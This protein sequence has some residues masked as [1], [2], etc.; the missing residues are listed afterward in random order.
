MSDN[1]TPTPST[2]VDARPALHGESGAGAGRHGNASRRIADGLRAAILSGELPPGTRIRQEEVAANYG[3][4]RIPVRGALNILQSDGLVTLV[5]NAGAWVAQLNLAEC[6]EAYQLREQIEPLLLRASRPGLTA[7]KLD[8]MDD[9]A[10]RMERAATPE[11][12]LHLDREFHDLSYSGA[13]TVVLSD[14]VDR[15]WNMTQQY[16]LA[17]VRLFDEQG[18]AIVHDEHRMLVRALREGDDDQAG[19][20]MRGHIRRT[21]LAL[22]QHPE[23]FDTT[24]PKQS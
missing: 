12:F 8:R 9:L 10:S 3:A 22:A 18:S 23:L 16:R 15:L 21:R 1:A 4:S 5:A 24:T 14:F 11:E 2:P 13:E 19:L 20:V 6:E 17:F 7:D